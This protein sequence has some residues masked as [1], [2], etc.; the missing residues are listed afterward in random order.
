[1]CP[2]K[3]PTSPNITGINLY[4]GR[5]QAGIFALAGLN[6]VATTCYFYY[7]Y[8]FMQERFGFGRMENLILAASLGFIYTF[9]SIFC[10]RF[11]QRRGYF[12]SL[13]LGFFTMAVALAAGGHM[14][15]VAGH[16][17][18]M[19]VCT[20][21]MCFTWPALEA[22]VSE[23]RSPWRLQRGVGIYNLVWAG[24]GA[25]AY[26]TGGAMLE[27]IGLQSMFLVPSVL[28]ATQLALAVWLENQAAAAAALGRGM[29]TGAASP[30]QLESNPRP[31]GTAR[32]FL[33]MAWLANPLAYLAINTVIAVI[34]SLAKALGLSPMFAGF[35]CSVW[36]FVRVGAFAL[37]WLWTGWHYRFGWLAGAY[38]AMVISFAL[39]LLAPMVALLVAAQF[40]FGLSV[41]LIY[42]SSLFYSMDVGETKGEH[43]GFHEAAIGAGSCAGP[44]I[45]A[46]AL[47]FFPDAPGSS[48]WAVSGMLMV[49]LAGLTW[50]RARK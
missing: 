6:S 20:V 42:S 30:E 8:F 39:I 49:G 1:M 18:V 13:R 3:G 26:F 35:F 19:A 34:P 36:L 9:A 43:G 29:Q 32:A 12:V 15:A 38:A 2:S 4:S 23:G 40:A 31:A 21:G 47:H 33:R 10:G 14:Q 11:A 28:M 44:A 25:L 46:A 5:V 16:L 17:A 22:M 24:G 50:L 37:L 45:G 27:K 41:G 7:V 48:A